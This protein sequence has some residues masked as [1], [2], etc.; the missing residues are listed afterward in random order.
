[1]PKKCHLK[2]SLVKSLVKSLVSLLLLAPKHF[3]VSLA[4]CCKF[5]LKIVTL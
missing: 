1:M 2:F 5:V 4:N 3:I